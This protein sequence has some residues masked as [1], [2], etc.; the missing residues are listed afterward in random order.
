LLRFRVLLRVQVDPAERV[1]IGRILGGIFFEL[2]RLLERGLRLV[3][4]LL[5]VIHPAE[6]A[7]PVG[8]SGID[9]ERAFE[10]A[11]R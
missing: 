5:D 10:V 4:R 3:V 11:A 6:L 7:P 2:N 8:I 9:L 1:P